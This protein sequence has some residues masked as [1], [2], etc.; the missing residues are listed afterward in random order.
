MCEQTKLSND[1]L[2]INLKTSILFFIKICTIGTT[3]VQIA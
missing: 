2:W 3:C 1:R